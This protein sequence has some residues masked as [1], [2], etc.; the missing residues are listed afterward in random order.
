MEC[1]TATPPNCGADLDIRAA[2]VGNDRDEHIFAPNLLGRNFIAA[3]PNRIWLADII[4]IETDQGWLYLATVLDL[5]RCVGN[6]KQ[7]AVEGRFLCDCPAAGALHEP[8]MPLLPGDGRNKSISHC[9]V[10][11]GDCHARW[12]HHLDHN[13]FA[14]AVGSSRLVR[15]RWSNGPR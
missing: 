1:V 15:L 11:N 4:Y 13:C 5:Y 14:G 8:A 9:L 6:P 10:N 12:W 2:L 3:A 7:V